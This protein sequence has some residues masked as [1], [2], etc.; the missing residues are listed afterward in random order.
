MR[1]KLVQQSFDLKFKLRINTNS[2]M[3]L[4]ALLFVRAD[5]K[6]KKWTEV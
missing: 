3:T 1:K 2:I 4:L 6:W 5:K